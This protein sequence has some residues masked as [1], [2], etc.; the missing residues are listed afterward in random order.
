MTRLICLLILFPQFA[1]FQTMIPIRSGEHSSFTRLVLTIDPAS[2]WSLVETP[3]LIKVEF[4][5]QLLNFD[6][7]SIFDRIPKTRI[8]GISAALSGDKSVL[9]IAVPCACPANIFAF[10]DN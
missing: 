8:S 7:G 4:P 6:T 5:D 3:G 1:S 2:V 10:G 9:N